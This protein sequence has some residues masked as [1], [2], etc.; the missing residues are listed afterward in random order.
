[1]L[2]GQPTGLEGF[3]VARQRVQSPGQER[4]WVPDR[5]RCPASPL[6][7]KIIGKVQSP[8]AGPRLGRKAIRL[9]TEL[10]LVPD[11]LPG[12]EDL[13]LGEQP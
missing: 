9:E 8:R 7:K 13:L 11:D 3:P 4:R 5:L 6:P 2:P 12:L 1:M 10:H